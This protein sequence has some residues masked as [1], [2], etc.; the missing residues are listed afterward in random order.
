MTLRGLVTP[1]RLIAAIVI[2]ALLF[3]V[4]GGEYGTRDWL[5]LKAQA[6]EE[7]DLLGG[8]TGEVDSLARVLRRLEH[9]PATQEKVAR[10]EFGMV[11]EGEFLFRLIPGGDGEGEAA[12]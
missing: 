5:E 2:L 11:R 8:L 10:E 9:D 12:R 6:R 7:R 4:E 1:R 3:G